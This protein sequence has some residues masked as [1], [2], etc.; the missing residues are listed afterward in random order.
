MLSERFYK[1]EVNDMRPEIWA[2]ITAICWSVGSLFEKKGVMLGKFTPV[3]GTTIRTSVSLLFLLL[4]SFPYWHQV[5]AAGIKP[6]V[7][8][9]VG[10]GIIAGGLGVTALCVSGAALTVFFKSH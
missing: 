9:A 5:K 7:M 8:I 10:G 4:I 3:M 2:I 6:V 1:K